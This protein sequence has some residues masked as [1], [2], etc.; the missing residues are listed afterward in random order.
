[1]HFTNNEKNLL[2]YN[3]IKDWFDKHKPLLK[4]RGYD[5]WVKYI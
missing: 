5:K 2:L 4:L 3:S 1:M